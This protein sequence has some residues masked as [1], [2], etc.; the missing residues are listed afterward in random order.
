MGPLTC[1]LLFYLPK[2]LGYLYT[3]SSSSTSLLL[4]RSKSFGAFIIN[5]SLQIGIS[6]LKLSLHLPLY[7][8]IYFMGDSSIIESVC[9]S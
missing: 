1:K 3:L 5:P 8:Y 2:L 9:P 7:I 6:L 4:S